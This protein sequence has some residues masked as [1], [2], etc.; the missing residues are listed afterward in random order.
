MKRK[1]YLGNALFSF[2]GT[3]NTIVDLRSTLS[4]VQ[5]NNPRSVSFMIQTTTS[6][7]CHNVLTTGSGSN[8]GTAFGIQ[9]ACDGSTKSIIA[10]NG[11]YVVYIPS[12]GEVINDGLWHTVLVTYDGITLTIYVDGRLDNTATNWNTGSSA[13][14]ASTLN[15]IGNDGNYLGSWANTGGR[16]IGKMK[17]VQFYNYVITN[18]YA[19]ANSYQTAGSVIYNSGNSF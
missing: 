2:D 3:V 15:T 13:T 12:G 18:T 11:A 14:I 7:G 8:D 6:S 16:W 9:F 5:G 4:C 10:F 17:N 19:L 1:Y